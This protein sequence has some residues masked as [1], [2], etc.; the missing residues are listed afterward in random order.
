MNSLA[1]HPHDG[2]WISDQLRTLPRRFRA[3]IKRRYSATFKNRGRRAANLHMLDLQDQLPESV[4]RLAADDH[5]LVEYARARAAHFSKAIGSGPHDDDAIASFLEQAAAYGVAVPDPIADRTITP[6]GAI[7]RL[8]DE[9]WWRRAIRKSQGRTVEEAARGL[10]L[11][12]KGAGIYSSDETLYRRRG[13]KS[14]NRR[15]LEE[16]LAVNE[17][18]QEYTLAELA[19][20]SVSN[21]VI[22]RGELM[23]RIAGFEAVAEELGHVGEFI[24]LTCPSRMHSHT[25]RRDGR[26]VRNPRYDGTTPRHAQK[27]LAKV[28]ARIRSKLAR[29]GVR[30][31]G[32][33]V[34][35]PNHDG[36]PHWHLLV[37]FPAWQRR[38]V[39][40]TF[41]T[42]GLCEDAGEPGAEKH[43][44]TFKAID[45]SR[46]TA[47]GYIAKYIAKN[48]DGFALDNDLFG[49]DP[50]E[51]A[52]RVDAWA[53]CWGIRQF[54][55]VGGPPVLVWR[56]LRRM[57]WEECGELEEA[58]EAA[59]RGDWAA[60]VM[61]MGGP[62]V[63]RKYL[64]ARPAYLQEINTETGE[65]PLNKYG[66]LCAGQMIG[67]RVGNVY[68]V[69]RWHEWRFKN[70]NF[71]YSAGSG[72][73]CSGRG[74]GVEFD[75]GCNSS[76]SRDIAG[77]GSGSDV[78]NAGRRNGGDRKTG[79]DAY[80]WERLTK[81]EPIG[82]AGKAAPWSSVNNCTQRTQLKSG[83]GPP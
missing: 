45:K 77:T 74:G 52:E 44:V 20:L 1:C 76:G 2:P 29:H 39:R 36:C 27:Y 55:Q 23:T 64:T 37:F 72:R 35:E 40:W 83:H 32:F 3:A 56:E 63:K 24:T 81:Q 82:W 22:R 8:K 69:T 41:W 31:Y 10:G 79:L 54:Q 70:G 7:A 16:V 46:G 33:R 34:T 18:G 57:D 38:R 15:M 67:V 80:G 21:P 59:D 42:H 12:H 25:I 47:A 14:R 43:R 60:F 9:L 19:E 48:I 51:A 71:K 11:V 75:S 62:T 28:F 17:E 78:C 65:L 49:G 58:R 61:A 5:E 66:E 50:I 68:H 13:Q 30:L 4:Y 73:A 53:S 26:S 6:Q